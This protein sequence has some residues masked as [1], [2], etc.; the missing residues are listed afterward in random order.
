MS[1]KRLND[2]T[3]EE[4]LNQTAT[5]I[6]DYLT[7]IRPHGEF[8]LEHCMTKQ[9]NELRLMFRQSKGRGRKERLSPWEIREL[10]VIISHFYPM[11]QERAR[12][13]QLNYTKGEALWIIRSTAAGESIRQ[14]LIDSGLK[15]EIECQRYRAKVVVDL[16]G[17]SLRF[18]VGYKSLEQEGML[19][20][21]IS[22]V[23]DLKDAV[24]RIGGDVKLG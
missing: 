5:A 20:G 7:H 6:H 23:K 13:A 1:M 17:R 3:E 11:M 16:E 4:I 21:V 22:A 24:C 15:A 2:M 12:A 8:I 19:T 10:D 9:I 14:A 18:Y